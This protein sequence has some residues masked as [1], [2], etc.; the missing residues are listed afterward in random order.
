M[1]ILLFLAG[2]QL[3][4]PMVAEIEGIPNETTSLN[5]SSQVQQKE[6]EVE[7]SIISSPPPILKTYH[8]QGGQ[9]LSKELNR[10]C[11]GENYYLE[12]DVNDPRDFLLEYNADIKAPHAKAVVARAIG[13]YQKLGY[14][15]NVVI[16]IKNQN[17]VIHVQQK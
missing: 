14:Y 6:V 8:L 10:I 2:C 15:N 1:G 3:F 9:L 13:A 12:W 11:L 4:P 7:P 16:Y 5:P 17:R